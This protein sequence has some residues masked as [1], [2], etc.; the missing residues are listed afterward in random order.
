MAEKVWT[1]CG[2]CSSAHNILRI[3]EI[4][5][6]TSTMRGMP[7]ELF[8]LNIEANATYK[9]ALTVRTGV[10]ENAP[11]MDLTGWAPRLQIRPDADS[12]NVLLDCSLENGRLAI[13]ATAGKIFL[14]L[15]ATDTARMS[16]AEAVYDMII[17]NA[18][19]TR[20]ILQGLVVVSKA[21]TK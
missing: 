14:L 6:V 18:A 11:P 17:S 10:D 5:V 4:R 7:A 16:F 8:N 1:N 21:V 15:S 12:L 3:C 13:S 19:E 20:R 9:L 2:A